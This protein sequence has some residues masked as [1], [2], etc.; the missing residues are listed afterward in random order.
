MSE[1]MSKEPWNYRREC[2]AIMEDFLRLRHKLIPY[3][4]TMNVRAAVEDEPLIQPLY[5]EYTK[6]MDARRST[7]QYI[8]GSELMVAPITKPRHTTALRGMVKAWL[9][10]MRRFV[11]IFMG[12]VYGGGGFLN[13]YRQLDHI[14]VFAH[15]GAIIP[16]DAAEVPKN[17][18]KNP[19]NHKLIVVVGND[20]KFNIVED[21]SDDPKDT[22][23]KQAY[24]QR[25][26]LIT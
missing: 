11:D 16:F 13:V 25:R 24:K 4:Y 17:G 18:K 19:Q 23:I 8:F 7:N 21:I 6:D 1:W 22:T 14:P 20:G 10:L 26:T 9:P 5:W 12:T 3:L 15:K 2:E